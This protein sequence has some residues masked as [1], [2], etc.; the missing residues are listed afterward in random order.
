MEKGGIVN[1]LIAFV[2]FVTLFIGLGKLF[3]FFSIRRSKKAFTSFITTNEEHDFT[4]K[5]HKGD[6]LLYHFINIYQNHTQKST[7]YFYNHFR[8]FLLEEVPKFEKGLNEMAAWTSVA[9]LLGLLGTVVGMVK[10]FTIITHFGIGNPNLLA[11]GI[12]I[13]LLTTQS[14]LIVAFPCLLFHNYLVGKK[15]TIVKE[16]IS[17]IE[18]LLIWLDKREKIC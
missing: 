10:T 3:M 9:P 11:E 17:D 14:G 13:A 5:K 8:E 7:K 12:S 15:N 16:L 18:Q 2:C 6:W 1:V 4:L